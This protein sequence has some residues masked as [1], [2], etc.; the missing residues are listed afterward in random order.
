MKKEDILAKL[1]AGE[2]QVK[3]ASKLLQE[4]EQQQKRLLHCKV[5]QKGAIS[6][7]GLATDSSHAVC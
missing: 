6:V 3:E 1:A 7:Y 5:S 2:M 4:A